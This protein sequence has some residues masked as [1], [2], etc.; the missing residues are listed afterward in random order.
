MKTH[1]RVVVVGGGVTG[2][3]VLYHLVRKGWSDVVLCERT[4][5]TAGSTWHSAGHVIQY[6]LD[7]TIG[8][9]NQYSVELYR[10]LEAETGQS[11]GFH[12]CG[13]LRLATHPDRLDELRRYA[14][15]A[16]AIGVRTEMLGPTEIGALW[17]LM[18]TDGILAGILNL[19]DGHIA[20]ADLTQALAAG[21]RQGGA[22]IYRH[23]EVLGLEQT[24]GG[25][26]QVHTGN[27]DITC[28]HVVSCTG[29]YAFQTLQRVGL[30]AH[31]VPVKHQFV[32]TEPIEELRR[33]KADG[34]P[35][36]PVMRDPERS[37]YVRQEGVSLAMGAYEER[38]HTVFVDG[39]PAT[40]GQDLFPA[41]LD[42]LLPYF[43][44][45]M[46]RVPALEDAGIKDV[47]NGP[48]PYSPD[49]LPTTGPAPGRRNLWLGEG[50]PFGITLAGGIGWQLAEWIVEGEPSIDMWACD[51]RRFG[52]WASRRW[53]DVKTREACEHTY[54][55]PKPGEEL[56]AG[57]PLRVSPLHD[58][59]T[60]RGAVFGVVAGWER[61]NWFAPEGV[62]AR[63]E[64][65][66]HRAN[67]FDTVGD[68][69][70]AIRARAGIA[71]L[72]ARSCLR[73]SGEDARNLLERVL[74]TR[75]PAVDGAAADGY[76]LSAL[77]TVRSQ[78]TVLRERQDGY[79][80]F[81][82]AAA[83]HY[84]L[85]LL[86]RERRPRER[87]RVDNLTGREGAL[88]VAGP[89]AQ[90]VLADA[91]GKTLDGCSPD[92]DRERGVTIGLAPARALST[93]LADVPAWIVRTPAE[94]LRHCYL[95]IEAAGD[96]LG[97]VRFGARAAECLR[98]E[99]GAP[100]W[101]SELTREFA[102]LEAG[103]GGAI[104]LD[105]EGFRGHDAVLA[106]RERGPS[107]A[108]V[109]LELADTGDL[110]ALGL[111]PIRLPDGPTIGRTTSGAR[112][113]CTGASM[114]LGYVDA[115]H[116]APGT[117]CEACLL[118]NW[119]PARIRAVAA[120]A[121]TKE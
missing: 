97:L 114:A 32:I 3:S 71:D 9:L 18:D 86:E 59:L 110:D 34:L 54:L 14:G 20:P 94:L 21:A 105:R 36:L 28:E 41:E 115:T 100:A 47:I 117:R 116:A 78:F 12:T 7:A 74:C 83:E 45:A 119:Y 75:L 85:D 87:V 48:M 120:G 2:C 90:Q 17:P 24:A 62:E 66:F 19:D 27:G 72:T 109:G 8:R 76:A 61:P 93:T 91:C 65:S 39:V 88:I 102:A 99:A 10:R 104:A 81:G 22:K 5:L 98:V 51:S 49:D 35:E 43:E 103:L 111:E 29:N 107:R 30:T 31:S 4:E 52:P 1:A 69:C 53:C 16:S 80:L 38:G 64:C 67:Y 113:H 11:P 108:L 44:Q 70:R 25:E 121:P 55:L 96:P 23:T 57:R 15:I 56:P 112:G 79:L 106:G 92:A 40:F 60:A 89:H 118:G 82:P 73:V 50:N 37:F 68:E 13:N 42:G 46:K 95:A 101:G 84:D 26:W 63:D 33:R 58:V 77:G 6:T